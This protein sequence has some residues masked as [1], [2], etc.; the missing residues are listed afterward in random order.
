VKRRKQAHTTRG[1][2][3][4]SRETSRARISTPKR[5][6]RRGGSSAPPPTSRLPSVSVS[7][8]VGQTQSRFPL[9]CH[10]PPVVRSRFPHLARQCGLIPQP[11]ITVCPP[12]PSKILRLL[13][14]K[15]CTVMFNVESLKVFKEVICK[16][17]LEPSLR[18]ETPLARKPSSNR[19][20]TSHCM[21]LS[22]VPSI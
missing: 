3:E 22:S 5:P 11:L 18:E 19:R 16:K 13:V 8:S 21:N 15:A 14:L 2:R 6:G 1:T 7:V 4:S 12:R 9:R 20:L 10:R 17:I